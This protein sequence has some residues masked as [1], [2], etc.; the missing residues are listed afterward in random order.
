MND[1]RQAA[2]KNSAT[3][4]TKKPDGHSA[5]GLV[6]DMLVTDGPVQTL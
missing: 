1:I 2:S 4:K 3:Q 5:T 6:G